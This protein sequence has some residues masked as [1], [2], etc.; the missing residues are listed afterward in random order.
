LR[1]SFSAAATAAGFEAKDS[2]TLDTE[3]TRGALVEAVAWT[4]RDPAMIAEAVKLAARYRE[5]PQA[6][7]GLVLSVAVDAKPE[8]WE[9][10]RKDL[11]TETDRSR[12]AE[13]LDALASVRDPA[14][15][16]KALD[17]ALDTKLDLRETKSVFY[18]GSTETNREAARAFFIKHDA[19]ILSRMPQDGTAGQN[20]GFAWL[21]TGT[22]RA[23]KRDAVTAYVKKT[24]EHLQGGP[25]IVKQALESMNTCIAKRSIL[26]AEVRAWLSGLKIPKP[27]KAAPEKVPAKPAKA[28]AKKKK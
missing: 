19:N 14:L 3:D 12:R 17:I 25:R 7:R 22:C 6:M 8:I 24:F 23:E 13:M 18:Q 28:P 2:D 9:Q 16:A 26:E 4:A 1:S 27:V 5:L 20:S 21:F 11:Y 15:H 10:V